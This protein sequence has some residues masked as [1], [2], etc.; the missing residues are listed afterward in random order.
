MM[1]YSITPQICTIYVYIVHCGCI[2]M[3]T[4]SIAFLELPRSLAESKRALHLELLCLGAR[5]LHFRNEHQQL[6]QREERPEDD[7]HREV[8]A[9]EH[10]M[11]SLR[12]RMEQRRRDVKRADQQ[13]V[14]MLLQLMDEFEDSPTVPKVGNQR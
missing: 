5:L 9:L 8:V 11:A 2:H 10:G 13:R 7:E 12:A 3:L 1:I 14:G 4:L 6:T